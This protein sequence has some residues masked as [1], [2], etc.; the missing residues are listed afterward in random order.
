MIIF[1]IYKCLW[2][3]LIEMLQMGLQPPQ[4]EAQRAPLSPPQE[5]ESSGGHRP[6]ELSSGINNTTQLI[7]LG[8]DYFMLS[9]HWHLWVFKLV[10]IWWA[11]LL[12]KNWGSL[13][14]KILTW[15]F[16]LPDCH[17]KENSFLKNESVELSD[18]LHVFFAK[19]V[20][21]SWLC[22]HVFIYCF[23]CSVELQWGPA[24]A[25]MQHMS[26]LL[27]ILLLRGV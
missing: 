10:G 6:L 3:C 14:A 17:V 22:F 1:W 9:N 25:V 23:V 20:Q 24:L 18:A 11:A 13:N 27:L 15:S 4:Q 7:T 19:L 21:T 2:K 5:L 16:T 8:F 12:I 26:G